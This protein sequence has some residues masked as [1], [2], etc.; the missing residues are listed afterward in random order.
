MRIVKHFFGVAVSI[1]GVSMEFEGTMGEG[2]SAR[3]HGVSLDSCMVMQRGR[4]I[5]D[6]HHFLQTTYQTQVIVRR[7]FTVDDTPCRDWKPT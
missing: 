6:N 5:R 3:Y 4:I 2:K 7:D 1:H